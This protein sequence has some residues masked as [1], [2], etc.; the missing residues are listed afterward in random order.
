MFPTKLQKKHLISISQRLSILPS[1]F[2]DILEKKK[3]KKI[4]SHRPKYNP[5]FIVGSPR[6]GSTILY[7]I[8][9]NYFDLLYIDNLTSIFYRNL[10]FGFWLDEKIFHHRPHNCFSSRYGNTAHCGLKG[11]SECGMFWYQWLP[12]KKHFIDKNEISLED[13]RQISNI[14][15]ALIRTYNKPLLFKNL[16]MGQR[17][18]LIA[19]FAPKAKFIFIKRNSLYMAQSIFMTRKKLGIADKDWWSV[20]P[21]NY[22]EL[23]RL[24]LHEK[25]VKQIYYVE[26]QINEDSCLF[27][28]NNIM[29]LSY[30]ELCK[31]PK[32]ITSNFSNFIDKNLSRKK[33]FAHPKIQHKERIY[34]EQEDMQKLKSEISKLSWKF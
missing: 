9:T 1:T 19:E 11:P 23:N 17:M 15:F 8:L 25:I 34:L 16:N 33:I 21:K 22:Q 27:P 29:I 14:I 30:E 18:R 26:K 12:R 32:K 4:S 28:K 20:K 5:I 7:Q 31:N 24:P 3:I 6:S 2:L 10:Y 13:R